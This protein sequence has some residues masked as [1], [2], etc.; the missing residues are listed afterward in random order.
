MG[1]TLGEDRPVPPC[2]RWF[3]VSGWPVTIHP[4]TEGSLDETSLRVLLE[5]LTQHS[6]P[7]VLRLLRR[8]AH[9][10]VRQP[11]A[12][13]RTARRRTGTCRGDVDD[14]VEPLAR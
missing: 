1:F 5:V 2:H 4:P 10:G 7:G 13:A 3:P 9:G 12:A 11:D 8:R 6:R 14:T